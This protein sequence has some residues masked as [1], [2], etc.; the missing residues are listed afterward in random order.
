MKIALIVVS[1]MLVI[2]IIIIGA[3]VRML[4]E[5]GSTLTKG[6]RR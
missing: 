4:G 5:V 2:A 3:F 1:G 6:F